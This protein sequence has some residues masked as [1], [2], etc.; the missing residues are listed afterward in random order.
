MLQSR[1]VVPLSSVSALP[2]AMRERTAFVCLH[3]LFGYH[4]APA[5][6]LIWAPNRRVHRVLDRETIEK[7]LIEYLEN[8]AGIG[9]GLG[10]T[11]ALISSGMLD[12]FDV[13]QLLSV[14]TEKYS[15]TVS[16]FDV[17]VENFDTVA[18]MSELVLSRAS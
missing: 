3:T 8:E 14:L 16:A 7:E 13:V 5:W 4:P 11:E 6:G 2:G 9:E 12:S 10:R 17:N 1:D 18:A 15:I